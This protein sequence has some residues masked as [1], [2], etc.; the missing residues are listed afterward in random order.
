MYDSVKVERLNSTCE[1]E[2]LTWVLKE[3]HGLVIQVKE[4]GVGGWEEHLQQG[5]KYRCGPVS[6]H[7]TF[8]CC[9][10]GGADGT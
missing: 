7:G 6:K 4:S 9:K 8:C 1:R 5:E 3:V 10:Q 2:S